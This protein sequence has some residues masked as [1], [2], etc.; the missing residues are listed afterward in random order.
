[1]VGRLRSFCDGLFS[2][3]MLNF[4]GV[5]RSN[6]GMSKPSPVPPEVSPN[7]EERDAYRLAHQIR[8]WSTAGSGQVPL[9]FFCN[10]DWRV[11]WR[12]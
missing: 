11:L 2:G 6:L 5:F 9:G 1:M 10:I 4:Q 3:A 12:P 7:Y 8:A